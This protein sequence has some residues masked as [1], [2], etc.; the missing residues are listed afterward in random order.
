MPW[1]VAVVLNLTP[2][3]LERHKS[4]EAYGMIKCRIFSHMEASDVA[5]VP[6]CERHMITYLHITFM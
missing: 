2:D 6:Q 4:M 5:V 3:H 1:Q